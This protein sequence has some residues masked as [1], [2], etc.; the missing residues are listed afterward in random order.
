MPV[1]I[2]DPKTAFVA[3]DLQK[4]IVALAGEARLAGVIANASALAAAFRAKGLPVVLVNVA[5]AAPGRSEQKRSFGELPPDWTE[6][7]PALDPQP[8]DIRI[9]KQSW[10]AFTGTDLAEQLNARGVTEVVLAGVS[11]SI[12]VESTAR[13]AY[14]L[15]FNVAL[16]TDAMADLSREAHE[17]SVQRI[18]PRLGET[19]RTQEIVALLKARP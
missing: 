9:T 8:E 15:G 10:G 11:T 6:I 19:G 1:T 14:E 12:G 5:G 2:L 17:N 18:F 13:Q 16:A 7:D 3:V 4:G